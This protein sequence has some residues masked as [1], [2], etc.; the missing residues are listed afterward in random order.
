MND[1]LEAEEPK[2]PAEVEEKQQPQAPLP[3]EV[4]FEGLATGKEPWKGAG[5]SNRL[6]LYGCLFGLIILS[7][8]LI[9]GTSMMR[10]TVWVNME[11][12]RR[13]V[14]RSLPRNLPAAER[15][16]TLQNLDR[17][18]AVLEASKDPYPT[19]GEFM[20]RVRDILRDGRLTAEEVGGLNVFLE[21]VIE[22]SG[23]PPMQLG[24]L[25]PKP[26]APS[27]KPAFA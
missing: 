11:R 15:Q 20:N 6:P 17:F 9:A 1:D 7:G 5:C 3:T 14:V 25:N 26:R 24:L 13:V 4:V 23:I 27:L 10:R 18:R 19:M 12:G 21:R 22:E 16:R 2:T 8:F